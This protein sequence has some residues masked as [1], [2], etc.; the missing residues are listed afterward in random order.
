MQE[1]QRNNG[2]R[3]FRLSQ[4][5]LPLEILVAPAAI[6][7]ENEALSLFMK[8]EG[9]G[10]A[11]CQKKIWSLLVFYVGAYGMN[12]IISFMERKSLLL[13]KSVLGLQNTPKKCNLFMEAKNYLCL[14]EPPSTSWSPP[15]GSL[16][17]INSDAAWKGFGLEVESELSPEIY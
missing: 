8:C 3:P 10:F 15:S 1:L 14:P 6:C 16:I 9:F 12:E 7:W 5:C 11:I 4:S 2:A 17:K 13:V